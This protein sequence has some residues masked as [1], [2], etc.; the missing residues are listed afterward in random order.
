MV[1]GMNFSCNQIFMD[2]SHVMSC[3]TELYESP[4]NYFSFFTENCRDGVTA[5]VSFSYPIEYPIDRMREIAETANFLWKTTDEDHIVKYYS[6]FNGILHEIPRC[7]YHYQAEFEAT[8]NFTKKIYEHYLRGL[9][10]Q[11]LKRIMYLFTQCHL[12]KISH[13]LNSIYQI[14][15]DPHTFKIQFTTWGEKN[16]Y[17]VE[18][19]IH[20][21]VSNVDAVLEFGADNFIPEINQINEER[22]IHEMGP[23][24]YQYDLEC[25][26]I[27]LSSLSE[28]EIFP[29]E[30]GKFYFQ[31]GKY[32]VYVEVHEKVNVHAFSVCPHDGYDIVKV[33]E[34]NL[35]NLRRQRSLDSDTSYTIRN[36]MLY[37]NGTYRFTIYAS[38]R[39]AA[40]Q[41]AK[42]KV[43]DIIKAGFFH[44]PFNPFCKVNT[45]KDSIAEHNQHPYFFGKERIMADSNNRQLDQEHLFALAMI[46]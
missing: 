45:L 38:S 24:L 40:V 16:A 17:R 25:Q 21:L 27:Q 3:F 36:G 30:V 12:Q 2:E 29:D 44:I 4:D 28:N 19:L 9:Q 15:E 43:Y 6:A 41:R 1:K 7:Q 11:D 46:R 33:A 18:D 22:P 10:G 14:P 37:V 26:N 34:E 20:S 39:D 8:I 13:T 5:Y 23:S 31:Q 35:S 42:N 32:D